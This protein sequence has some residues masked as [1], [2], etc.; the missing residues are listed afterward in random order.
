MRVERRADGSVELDGY[1]NAVERDSAVL[2]GSRGPFVERV[3]AGTFERALERAEDV[4]LTYN[5]ARHLGSRSGGEVKLWED[6]IGLRARAVVSDSEVEARAV[7]GELTGWSF[8]FR[9]REGGDNWEPA[10]EGLERRTLTDIDLLEV[11]VLSKRPAYP[12]TMVE[13][14]DGGEPHE[15]RALD[16]GQEA[17]LAPQENRE[18]Q[19]T[20]DRIAA[21]LEARRMQIEILKRRGI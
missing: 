18:E 17:T 10:G 13:L 2:R 15:T 4:E 6:A 19:D 5:H 9:R 1:V 14:R 8:T 21:Q 7:A 16:D 12:A 11:S 20:T 3:A